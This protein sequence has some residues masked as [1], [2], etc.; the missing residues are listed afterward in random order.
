M[1]QKEYI[2]YNKEVRDK[3][4]NTLK[5]GDTVIFPDGYLNDVHIGMVDHFAE[6]TVIIK[7]KHP[8]WKHVNKVQRYSDRIIKI[9]DKDGNHIDLQH[10]ISREPEVNESH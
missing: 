3:V 2:K 10:N 6:R 4:G 1:T 5:P 8:M 7:Y 9:R